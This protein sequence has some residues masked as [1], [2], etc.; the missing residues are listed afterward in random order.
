MSRTFLVA[1]GQQRTK[2]TVGVSSFLTQKFILELQPLKWMA[3]ESLTNLTYSYKSDVW[4]FGIVLV[5][6][7]SRNGV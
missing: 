6:I 7:F 2:A 3:P 1:D 4:S 5:E